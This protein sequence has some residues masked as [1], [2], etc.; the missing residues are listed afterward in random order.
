MSL[1]EKQIDGAAVFGILRRKEGEQMSGMS[2]QKFRKIR[3]EL[4][5]SPVEMAAY[6]R[7]TSPAV[8]GRNAINRYERGYQIGGIPGPVAVATE[9]LA[10][11]FRPDCLACGERADETTVRDCSRSECPFKKKGS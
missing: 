11:G 10:S 5:F 6:L 8:S 2:P 1:S 7:L 3:T 4:G 9:A